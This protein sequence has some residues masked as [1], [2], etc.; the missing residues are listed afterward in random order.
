MFCLYIL[1]CNLL[2]I[3]SF[4][5]SESMS[6]V[7]A[8]S[9]VMPSENNFWINC[10]CSIS[11]CFIGNAISLFACCLYLFNIELIFQ[12]SLLFLKPYSFISA[13]SS[14]ILS[15]CQGCE[16]VEYFFLCFLGSPIFIPCL[17]LILLLL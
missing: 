5:E 6:S 17:L 3:R 15:F 12:I 1:V 11:A 9:P 14:S 16:G 7:F 8:F 10:F 4:N 13:F 2:S